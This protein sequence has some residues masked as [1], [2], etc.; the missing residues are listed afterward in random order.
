MVY[1]V[2]GVWFHHVWGIAPYIFNYTIY[3]LNE[4]YEE[5]GLKDDDILVI[6]RSEEF[7]EE[8]LVLERVGTE[9][10]V[11]KGIR[12]PY[13]VVVSSDVLGEQLDTIKTYL[14]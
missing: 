5:Y 11:T 3:I 9:Y 12:R 2:Y 13:G 4:D 1:F 8:D 6:K 10:R 7:S 14:K